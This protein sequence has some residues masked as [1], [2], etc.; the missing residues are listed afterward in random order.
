MLKTVPGILSLEVGAEHTTT[1]GSDMGPLIY[2]VKKRN[3]TG[4]T[5]SGIKSC[6]VR[7]TGYGRFVEFADLC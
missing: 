3:R 2:G 4:M 7:M 5:D 6:T 1:G